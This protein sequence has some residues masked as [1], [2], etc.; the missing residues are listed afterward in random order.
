MGKFLAKLAISTAVSVG[1]LLVER[2]MLKTVL[3]QAAEMEA[4]DEEDKSKG[5]QVE[6]TI[7]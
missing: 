7:Q 6:Y 5:Y 4:T 2:K 1:L 3:Q